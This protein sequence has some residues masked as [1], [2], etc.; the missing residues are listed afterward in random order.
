[1]SDR[2]TK[3]S[4]GKFYPKV[5]GRCDDLNI[6]SMLILTCN[7]YELLRLRNVLILTLE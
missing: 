7:S 6:P 3:K 2:I 4:F 1:L 5:K